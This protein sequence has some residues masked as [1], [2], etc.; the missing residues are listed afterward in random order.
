LEQD[1]PDVQ[2]KRKKFK[3]WAKK[4]D[5][6]KLVFIDESGANTSM[7]RSHAWILKGH[8][9]V[10]PRPMNWGTNLTMIGAIRSTGPI[11]MGTMFKSANGE[12][13][14]NWIE[15]RLAPKLKKGDI[16]ILDNARAHYHSKVLPPIKARGAD[17]KYLPPYSPDLNPIE[18]AWAL[19]KKDVRKFAP[20]N[21]PALR[22][23]AHNAYR[24]ISKAHCMGW[25]QHSGYLFKR[26]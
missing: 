7:G 1:R 17:L 22:K 3:L 12:R 15:R 26:N 9:L 23:V 20:R 10:D 6:K 18:P 11:T 24:K 2:L 21:R 25:F 19:V 5:P 16:V 14:S 8:E 13:F 4:V